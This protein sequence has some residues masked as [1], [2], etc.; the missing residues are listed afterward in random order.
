MRKRYIDNTLSTKN[1]EDFLQPNNLQRL[2]TTEIERILAR[3]PAFPV[4]GHASS[5]YHGQTGILYLLFHIHNVDPSVTV[6][7]DTI[8][9]L[10]AMYLTAITKSIG[11]VDTKHCGFV[12][13]PVGALALAA[14]VYHVV[15]RKDYK[16]RLY[17]EK[18]MEYQEIAL[19][20]SVSDELLYGRVGFLYA[21]EL[22][23]LHC[24]DLVCDLI[25]DE[26]RLR[27]IR[28]VIEHGRKGAFGE[29]PLMWSW[30]D[31]QYLG[32]AHGAGNV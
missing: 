32:A 17:V 6:A 29:W 15:L 21:L 13:S 1:L 23:R 26:S 2:L 19:K 10:C 12:D 14:C 20:D 22:V 3:L 28:K 18:L 8:A 7:G 11:G 24:P 31:R 16:A 30:H 4:G 27:V 5:I 9:E 25:T